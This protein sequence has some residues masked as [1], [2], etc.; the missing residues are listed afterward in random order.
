MDWSSAQWQIP[1]GV[2]L[3]SRGCQRPYQQC[4]LNP[5]V[6]PKALRAPSPPDPCHHSAMSEV[7]AGGKGGRY[8]PC[9]SAPYAAQG[10]PGAPA[11]RSQHQAHGR[12]CP[13]RPLWS[14]L[15][16]LSNLLLANPQHAGAVKPS[17]PVHAVLFQWQGPACSRRYFPPCLNN[18]SF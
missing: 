15:L 17:I 2:G 4:P 7:T 1:T 12:G 16:L 18:E 8:L 3:S 10:I 9:P 13:A 5:L 14:S 11:C 6:K